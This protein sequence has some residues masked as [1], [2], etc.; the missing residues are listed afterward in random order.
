MNTAVDWPSVTIVGPDEVQYRRTVAAAAV[1]YNERV[2]KVIQHLLS[3]S[4]RL[5]D[6]DYGGAA[7]D[8][9]KAFQVMTSGIGGLIEDA[10][11]EVCLPTDGCKDCGSRTAHSCVCGE[12]F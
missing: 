12:E 10:E 2:N 4:A 11:N 7:I 8:H 9:H 5:A 6:H 1:E 3:A